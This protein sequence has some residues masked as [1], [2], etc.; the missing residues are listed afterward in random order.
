MLTQHP[1]IVPIYEFD[2]K[3]G[4]QFFTMKEIVGKTLKE[5]M[6]VYNHPNRKSIWENSAEGWNF[7]KFISTFIQVAQTLE[8]AHSRG[9]VHR[10]IKPQNIMIGEFGEVLIVDW[11]M[12]KVN[13]WADQNPIRSPDKVVVP[14]SAGQLQER[15]QC[16]SGTPLY[17]PPEQL[18]VHT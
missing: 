15:I 18:P 4:V 1:G 10:D 3:D 11:G 17:M 12:A 16:I 8:F 5:Y 7:R 2:E 14:L 6:N 13:S 9:V